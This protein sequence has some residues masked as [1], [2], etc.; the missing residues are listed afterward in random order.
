M[1]S[2]FIVSLLLLLVM[3]VSKGMIDIP[4]EKKVTIPI[5]KSKDN[6]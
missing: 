5:Y 3:N 1:N 4:V 6:N 2:V